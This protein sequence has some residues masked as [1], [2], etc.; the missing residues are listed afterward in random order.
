M[1]VSLTNLPDFI[2]TSKNVKNIF[3]IFPNIDDTKLANEIKKR[4]VK[5]EFIPMC[6][7]EKTVVD[8]FSFQI[9]LDN[10]ED[11]K[12]PSSM[13]VEEKSF[14]EEDNGNYWNE[15][16]FDMD[17]FPLS[18]NIQPSNSINS[19]SDAN[20]NNNEELF[21]A[22]L[23]E[24]KNDNNIIVNSQIGSFDDNISVFSFSS[25]SSDM[26]TLPSQN[27]NK[28]IIPPN[29]S[30]P[31]TIK[32]FS[33]GNWAF[34]NGSSGGHENFNAHITK[35][36]EKVQE[37]H[38]NEGNVFEALAYRKAIGQIKKYPKKITKVS[39]ISKLKCVGTKIGEKIKEIIL[40]GKCKK[41]NF[42]SNDSKNRIINELCLVY[43]IGIKQANEFYRKGIYTIKQLRD[44]YTELPLNIQKGLDYHDNIQIK[45]PR[46]EV[47][48]IF[49]KVQTELYTILPKEVINAEVCGSYRRGK[50]LCGDI[51]ILITRT[52][53]GMIDGIIQT[54]VEKLMEKK[55]IVDILSLGGKG[56]SKNIFMG[57]CMGSSGINRRL[58]IKVYT[59]EEFPFAVL[60]FTGNAYFNRS[61]RLFAKK[62]K[63]HLSDKELSYRNTGK[64]IICKTEQEIFDALGIQYKTPKEREI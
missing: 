7:R 28:K 19:I 27:I 60:Y 25:Q 2:I 52:D 4:L 17:S 15:H 55:V 12:M 59:K 22:I 56:E 58:D 35:E 6:V 29:K 39:E 43:G 46:T 41:S 45:I 11:K 14:V 32:T 38:S 42:V 37:Y 8:T 40:T 9:I 23:K 44:M 5:H 48:E 34:L 20:N 24:V 49:E 54:L 1:I 26:S 53:E 51:D 21:D 61:M 3:D 47:K 64:K 13:I 50:E 30:A 36:L 62:K 33:K 18:Q 57:I 31:K 16:S 63:L 10:T